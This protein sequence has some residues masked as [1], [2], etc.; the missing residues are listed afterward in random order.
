MPSSLRQVTY[1]QHMFKE[2][3]DKI[4]NL[5]V[6]TASGRIE[7]TKQT[8]LNL[9]QDQ[10]VHLL[11]YYGPE[12]CDSAYTRILESFRM[13]GSN[14]F[15]CKN[16]T[17][18]EAGLENRASLCFLVSLFD[19]LSSR[20]CDLQESEA[21]KVT[22]QCVRTVLLTDSSLRPTPLCT[23][24]ERSNDHE[25][26][27]K[28][29]GLE[30]YKASQISRSSCAWPQCCVSLTRQSSSFPSDVQRGSK[31]TR[32]KPHVLDGRWNDTLRIQRG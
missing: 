21:R 2:F 24:T 32:P 5:R 20:F 4:N 26:Q 11:H 18:F 6:R 27:V 28:V 30:W 13:I 10:V 31:E 12:D 15:P 14:K 19:E 23:G 8:L 3:I 1:H 29:F 16:V 25:E 9:D 22:E 7:S 17:R